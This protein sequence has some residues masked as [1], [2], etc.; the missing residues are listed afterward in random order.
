MQVD[1]VLVVSAP[2]ELQR[3]RVL[4]RPGMNAGADIACRLQTLT[5]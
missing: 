2:A 5:M 4:A 1:A 3:E